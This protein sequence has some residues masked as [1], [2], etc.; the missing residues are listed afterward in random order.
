ME[1]KNTNYKNIKDYTVRRSAGD[2]MLCLIHSIIG[3]NNGQGYYSESEENC[4]KYVEN[5]HNF[6]INECNDIVNAIKTEGE[7]NLQE[8]LNIANQLF[9]M[10]SSGLVK[11][12]ALLTFIKGDFVCNEIKNYTPLQK[13]LNIKKENNGDNHN[14]VKILHKLGAIYKYIFACSDI[15]SRADLYTASDANVKQYDTIPDVKTLTEL[16]NNPRLQDNF[17][18]TFAGVAAV[19]LNKNIFILT[20]INNNLQIIPFNKDAKSHIDRIKATTYL[21][22]EERQDKDINEI[23]FLNDNEDIVIYNPDQ[24][25][26]DRMTTSEEEK[27]N[28]LKNT[29]QDA[30]IT[31]IKQLIQGFYDNSDNIND[32]DVLQKSKFQNDLDTSLK[33]MGWQT[34]K[35]EILKNFTELEAKQDK[36]DND[37]KKLY[38]FLSKQLEIIMPDKSQGASHPIIAIPMNV[39]GTEIIKG[40]IDSKTAFFLR[41][42]KSNDIVKIDINP[43]CSVKFYDSISKIQ[44]FKKDNQDDKKTIETSLDKITNLDAAI[45]EIARKVAQNKDDIVTYAN[46]MG[47]FT[48]T[49]HETL[50]GKIQLYEWQFVLLHKLKDTIQ[51][52]H[53]I[54]ELKNL[55]YLLN[56]TKRLFN[57]DDSGGDEGFLDCQAS[58]FSSLINTKVRLNF[59]II[60]T[61]KGGNDVDMIITKY[62]NQNIVYEIQKKQKMETH[63]ENPVST[64]PIPEKPE[65]KSKKIQVVI[66]GSGYSQK[67]EVDNAFI[68]EMTKKGYD[69]DVL[70]YDIGQVEN[71][72]TKHTKNS[73]NV[74]VKRV[75]AKLT[76]NKNKTNE[77]EQNK[78]NEDDQKIVTTIQESYNK[79]EHTLIID[80]LGQNTLFNSTKKLIKD[81]EINKQCTVINWCTCCTPSQVLGNSQTKILCTGNYGWIANTTVEENFKDGNTLRSAFGFPEIQI[82]EDI[83]NKTYTIK[84]LPAELKNQIGCNFPDFPIKTP[85]QGFELPRGNEKIDNYKN[86]IT[87]QKLV[88]LVEDKIKSRGE[89]LNPNDTTTE[90]PINTDPKM[91]EKI[92]FEK[93]GN[94]K[95]KLEIHKDKFRIFDK[96][97]NREIGTASETWTQKV[98]EEQLKNE[99][100][101]ILKDMNDAEMKDVQQLFDAFIT[102]KA[103]EHWQ[104]FYD[105]QSKVQKEIQQ[106]KFTLIKENFNTFR[107]QKNTKLAT[108]NILEKLQKKLDAF[109]PRIGLKQM[110]ENEHFIK[111]LNIDKNNTNNKHRYLQLSKKIQQACLQKGLSTKSNRYF[112]KE[113]KDFGMNSVRFFDLMSVAGIKSSDIKNQKVPIS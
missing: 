35:I 72:T 20:K 109:E 69:V 12:N 86:I 31:D 90:P 25:H 46:Q 81:C 65:E 33:K 29:E 95:N 67:Q 37:A 82:D 107:N 70:S 110:M 24:T 103:S 52:G 66:L 4:K 91:T 97:S 23:D 6:V 30:N 73:R 45:E 62:E 11:N 68:D 98:E 18:H 16:L 101:T 26:Y 87:A 112:K 36:T 28:I 50:K 56:N 88:A 79:Y 9:S 15:V 104:E 58:F 89:Q 43:E 111:T 75:Q 96:T 42:K 1:Q 94:V 34:W 32:S 39:A 44:E 49:C 61:D 113:D 14:L 105:N 83:K 108:E 57:L 102:F 22:N 7:I 59:K 48:N 10:Q 64:D 54:N 74:N 80:G 41:E 2:G 38:E 93:I 99:L 5:V 55:I 78:I 100:I 84:Q 71:S 85:D 76:H 13:Y 19:V 92:T 17:D 21:N 53:R 40:A 3:K 8:F 27:R 60:C 47:K 106:N 63:K 51:E 77:D